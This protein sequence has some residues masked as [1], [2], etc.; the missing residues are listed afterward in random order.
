MTQQESMSV[1]VVYEGPERDIGRLGVYIMQGFITAHPGLRN[2]NLAMCLRDGKGRVLR[3][4]VQGSPS[5]E[6]R[7]LMEYLFGD[8]EPSEAQPA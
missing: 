4:S 5:E 3:T 2:G 6:M 7:K 1:D 8:D